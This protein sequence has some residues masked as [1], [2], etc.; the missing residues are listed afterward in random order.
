M[1][2]AIKFII[3]GV[4]SAL[5]T[6]PGFFN[7]ANGQE[8]IIF[9]TDFDSDI[10]DVGALYML[11]TL[12]DRGEVDILATILST[13]HF[14]SPF[15]LD[16][17][18]AFWGRS[19]IPI[20]V[21][22]FEGVNKGSYYAEAIARDFPNDVGETKKVEDAT[23]LYRR[24][25]A[26]Q[27]DGSVILVSVGH[28]TNV[29]RLLESKPD[30]VSHLSG[31]ELVSLKVKHWVAMLGEGMNW[32]M[33][34]DRVASETAINGC[35]V[36]II[37]TTEGQ[38]VKTGRKTQDLLDNN[39]IKTVYRIWEEHYDEIDR[40]SWDQ[41]STLYAVKGESKMFRLEP[42]ILTFSQEHGAVWKAE[43]SGKD[44]RLYNKLSNE[45]MADAIEEL[46]IQIP[47]N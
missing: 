28:L 23:H 14:W 10:D 24:I 39:P 38:E 44:F 13:T 12:A 26:S 7:I 20:G 5:I 4:I 32:N 31:K 11:H 22:L 21:P 18:N 30:E 34:W 35:P 15:A 29:A 2:W 16:A 45:K 46:M 41:I 19:D 9:D 8:K 25:L 42:G 37:F 40:S 3:P 36:P 1:K 6:C 27:S 17:V 33:R 47:G 43:A